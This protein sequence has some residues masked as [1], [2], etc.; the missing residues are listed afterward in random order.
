VRQISQERKTGRREKVK[1]KRI[2][3][4]GLY[5]DRMSPENVSGVQERKNEFI[6]SELRKKN[7][8]GFNHQEDYE[9]RG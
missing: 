1:T 7:R 6:L 5:G 8:Y 9:R 2:P 3:V 4:M